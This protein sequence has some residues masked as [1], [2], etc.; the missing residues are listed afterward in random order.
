MP[1]PEADMVPRE[2]P[3]AEEKK[4]RRPEGETEDREWSEELQLAG[5]QKEFK[6]IL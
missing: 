5:L 2:L 1:G 6:F 4:V 3:M